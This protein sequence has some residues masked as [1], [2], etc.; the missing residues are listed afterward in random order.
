MDEVVTENKEQTTNDPLGTLSILPSDVVKKIVKLTSSKDQIVLRS[1]C[2]ELHE[3]CLDSHVE[4]K[5]ERYLNQ[6]RERESARYSLWENSCANFDSL[7]NKLVMM[8]MLRA[9]DDILGSIPIP[10][11]VIVPLV[12]KFA[13][14]AK[15][16]DQRLRYVFQQKVVFGTYLFTIYMK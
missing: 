6:M 5:W 16:D 15:S 12:K 9:F 7:V 11:S 3:I 8:G 10:P 2:K 14:S 1:M 13:S 4:Y